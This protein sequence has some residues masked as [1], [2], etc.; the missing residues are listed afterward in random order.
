[1]T[2]YFYDDYIYY[3][4]QEGVLVSTG[5][6]EDSDWAHAATYE[7]DLSNSTE[8]LYVENLE[9]LTGPFP[10]EDTMLQ[11]IA[12]GGLVVSQ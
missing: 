8:Y 1:M 9:T 10:T 11:A 12:N 5:Q 4:Y 3:A 6:H 7:N 2:H